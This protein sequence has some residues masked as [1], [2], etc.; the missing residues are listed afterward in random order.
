MLKS[1]FLAMI[2]VASQAKADCASKAEIDIFVQ[3][4]LSN[5]ATLA[6]T[7]E[8]TMEDALCTQARLAVAL[9]PYVG[10]VV[11]Y[12]AGLTSAAAQKRFGASEPVRGLLYRDMML[13]NGVVVPRNWGARAVFE[14]DLILVVGDERINHAATPDE[15]IQHVSVIRPFMELSDLTLSEEEPI[16]PVTLTAIGVG[17]RLGV[18]GPEIPVTDPATLS[19]A[20]G[21][22]TVTLRTADG[23]VLAHASGSAVLG[24]PAHAVL[25]LLSKNINFKKGDMISVGSFGPLFSPTKNMSGAAIT[26][27]GLPG[28]PTISVGF[29]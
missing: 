13:E 17:V 19:R 10:P 21:D 27:D 4:Y 22:M 16:T 7:P 26:Y 14:A 9:E 24:H 1:I 12:K 25:W 15:V 8:G 23:E 2:L 18:L 5:L 6:L 3:D 28:N 11:G 29:E 20:L